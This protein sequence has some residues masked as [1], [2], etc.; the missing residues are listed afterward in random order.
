ML[1]LTLPGLLQAIGQRQPGRVKS[2]AVR[3]RVERFQEW[4]FGD[5]V[6]AVITTGSYAAPGSEPP[7]PDVAALDRRALALMVIEAEDAR[8]AAEQR[9]AELQPAADAWVRMVESGG[10]LSLTAAAKALQ[11]SGA[12]IKAREFFTWLHEK[13]WTYRAGGVGD[14]TPYAEVLERGFMTTRLVTDHEQRT[15]PQARI[16]VL[17][18]EKLR[19]MLIA[20]R[21]DTGPQQTSM[22]LV[23]AR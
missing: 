17:G 19:E 18:M 12:Q 5:I 11:S 23:V 10:D 2:R 1:Y 3:A 6:P 22:Q 14:W 21:G 13:R 7:R 4:V 20:E 16:T 9:A 8:A 15:K